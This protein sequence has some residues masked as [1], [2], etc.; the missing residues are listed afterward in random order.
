MDTNSANPQVKAR[1][2]PGELR[3][4]WFRVDELD[5]AEEVRVLRAAL[6]GRP[7]IGSL[8]FDLLRGRMRVEFDARE[9]SVEAIL[10]QVAAAGL[11]ARRWS[12]ESGAPADQTAQRRWPLWGTAGLLTAL[13]LGLHAVLARDF[14]A[15]LG[16]DP[17][18]VDTA[19][20]WAARLVYGL[21]IACGLWVVLPRAWAALVRRRPDMH[22][23][24]CLAVGGALLLDDWLEAATV[25]FLFAVALWLEQNSVARARRAISRLLD[26]APDEARCRQP[27]GS[28]SLLPV[29]EVPPGQLIRVQPG[30]RIPL[31]GTIRS[32]Q[33]AVNQAPITGESLP[34]EKQA[35]DSVYAGTI[36][37][38]GLLEL[39]TTRPADDSTLARISRLIEQAQARRAPSE[40]WVERFAL[41]YTP[42]VIGL[43][44]LLALVPPLLLS[45]S[46][47]ASFYNALVLLVIACPCAL[48]ISTPVSIVSALA[49]A[50]RQGVLVKGGRYLEAFARLDAILFDKTGTLTTGRPVVQQLVPLGDMC[51]DELLAC[52]AALESHSSHPIAQAIRHHAHQRA[53]A[54]PAA[55][56][57]RMLPG[58]GAEGRVGGRSC[59]IGNRRLLRERLGESS[60]LEGRQAALEDA[61]HSVVILGDTD[62]V[63]GLISVQDQVR[64]E[65]A[66]SIAEL[67]AL[68]VR[69]VG[70]LTGD[71]QPT[72]LAVAQDLEIE[73]LLAEALPEDKLRYVEQHVR[74]HRA[75]AMVGDGVNDAPALAASHVGV[76]MGAIGTDTAIETA[77]VALMAD[78]MSKL[79]WLVRHARRTRRI[80]LQNTAFALGSKLLFVV[81][82]VLG[83]AT[84]WM[85]I[86][87]D[88]GASLLVI[89]NGLRLLSRR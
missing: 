66:R 55:E 52:A 82:A 45:G 22:L 71:N 34:R 5:C 14:T 49:S 15:A 79:P 77:D 2:G 42:A 17:G 75:V 32:G 36:N 84:L 78:D 62:G 37:G 57:F 70:M 8:E 29:S 80:I 7:G 44:L 43:A 25:S 21:A 67:R 86:A 27:D 72:A 73:D 35:G 13:G 24:M 11:H 74:Q 1:T 64:P 28:W 4:A 87:A 53:I 47:Q 9:T 18:G 40:Q 23:L 56:Q 76:A 63:L 30:E 19:V 48:V 61:G 31:D 69:R 60:I 89:F 65:A 10:E 54:V 6:E 81:L 46:W 12:G 16:H 38:E 88:M 33:S 39:V 26:L 59:W 68:G 51:G 3:S 83:L 58:K 85:A 41:W 20:P 50:A